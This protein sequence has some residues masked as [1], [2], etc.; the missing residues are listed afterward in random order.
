MSR[1]RPDRG[2]PARLALVFGHVALAAG[3]AAVV[4]GCSAERDAA[5]DVDVAA[6]AT[7]ATPIE[8]VAMIGDS[9]TVGAEAPLRQSLEDLGLEVVAIDAENGRRMIESGSVSSGTEA[10]ARVTQ[11]QPDLWTVALGT[12]DVGIYA[13][14]DEYRA[15]IDELLL[16]IPGGA[17]LV[18]VDIYVDM[19]A[20]ASDEFNA[21]LSDALEARGN[22]SVVPWADVAD[23][24]GVLSDGIHPSATGVDA[25]AELVAAGVAE[26]LGEREG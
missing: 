22:A 23:D 17:P 20:G 13:G 7:D 12:N 8:S 10:A 14:A 6:A 19:A 3:V 26:W 25:F 15:A 4:L 21:T 18:W 9:I 16:A 5:T 1:A 2:S 11:R 24:D